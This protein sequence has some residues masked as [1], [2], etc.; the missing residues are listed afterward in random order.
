MLTPSLEERIDN[1]LAQYSRS[2]RFH[3]S[4]QEVGL[5]ILREMLARAAAY[6]DLWAQN[7]LDEMQEVG[8]RCCLSCDR[9][10]G[11]AVGEQLCGAQRQGRS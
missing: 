2:R 10:G 7:I 3:V 11:D 5:Q 1:W 6:G 4:R 9:S 8:G